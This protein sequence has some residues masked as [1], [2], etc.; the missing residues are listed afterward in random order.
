MRR[1]AWTA[2]VVVAATAAAVSARPDA[3]PAGTWLLSY[4]PRGAPG[5]VNLCILKVETKDGRPTA[6]VVA[7]PPK[8]FPVTVK[9]V[10]VS[11][12]KVSVVLGNGT[13]FTGVAGKDKDVVL[14]GYG[15]E[16]VLFRAKLTRTDKDEI[17][18]QIT[19]AKQPEQLT[20]VTKLLGKAPQLRFKAQQAK[21]PEEKK[22][23]L[24]EAAAAAKEADEKVPGL[25][26]E[27]V[28]AHA[29]TPAAIDAALALLVTARK[30]GMKAD[31]ARTLMALI[32]KQAAAYGPDYAGFVTVQAAE[33]VAAAKGL[34]AVAADT[35]RP[36]VKGFTDKAPPA[37]TQVKLLT[38]LKAALASSGGDE[39]KAIEGKLTK[40]EGRLDEEYHA[41]VPPFKPAPFAG[42]KDKKANRAVVMELFTGAQ[43][44]PCVAADVAFD[45]LG[46]SYQPA[47]LVLIQYHLHIPG[48]DP[49]TN[50]DTNDRAKYYGAR[51]T[52]ST[53]FNGKAAAG[54][55]GG[56]ANAEAKYGKYCEVI[57]PLLEEATPVK[58]TGRATRTGDKVEVAVEY[59]GVPTDGEA[60]LRLLLVEETVKYVGGNR[61]R[62]HHA[63]VR[64]MPGGVAGTAI[65]EKAGRQT[66]TV[67]VTKVRGDL[68]KYL[69][70]F[71]ANT[72]FPNAAR[73]LDM[74][75]LQV[76]ALVQDDATKE[77]LQAARFDV[78]GP[79]PRA[80]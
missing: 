7:T 37:E 38:A 67:D 74:T 8:A 1:L 48:P 5:E 27:V 63:V 24:T 57:D 17:A 12:E 59:A 11:G 3:D 65:K 6:S 60:K 19:P 69:D 25:Y 75:K 77:I 41:K 9:E 43:C 76:I 52:P 35:L 53:F 40:L 72:P 21:E 46:K 44:P 28:K 55:G 14:G 34:E 68:T 16:S 80:E 66:V 29:E 71:A 22:A 13:L 47:E 51:S 10:K 15:N 18:S 42:R 54:G 23:L 4:S 62:F 50:P 39:L 70:E 26:R 78:A 56:M 58:V 31:E 64:A 36:M 45:A 61:L 33:A 32:T 49:M 20:E 79:G 30:S 73:P 2:A